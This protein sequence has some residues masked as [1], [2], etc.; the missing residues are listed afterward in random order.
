MH[1]GKHVVM[2]DGARQA[3]LPRQNPIKAFTLG[4]I[5]KDAGLTIEEVREL[6]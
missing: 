1:Q 3:T 4:G 6:L 5:I 2:S